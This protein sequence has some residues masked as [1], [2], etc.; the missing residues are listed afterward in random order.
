[1]ARSVAT[2]DKDRDARLDYVFDW[3]AQMDADSDSVASATVSASPS[4]LGLGSPNVTASTVQVYASGGTEGV[5]YVIVN[6]IWTAGG[7]RDDKALALRIVQQPSRTHSLVVEDG[8][9]TA[10]ANSYASVA[11]ADDYHAGHLYAGTWTAA[12]QQQREKALIMATRLLDEHVEWQGA[13]ADDGNGLQWPRTGAYDRGGW[14][15]GNNEVPADLKRA[16]AEFARLLLVEDRTAFDEPE[17][18]GFKSVRAGS[19]AFE[20][21]TVDRRRLIPSRVAAMIAPF[22]RIATGGVIKLV[23]A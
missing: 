7:R 10:D 5:T 21:E 12:D 18:A 23:R 20:V 16:A 17:T 9:G 1:M 11:D 8:S 14:L 22:G 3:S 15:I 6:H 13:K 4:G 2:A 19:L